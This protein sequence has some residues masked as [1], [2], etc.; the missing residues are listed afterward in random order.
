[1]LSTK[2]AVRD[3]Y[4]LLDDHQRGRAHLAGIPNSYI[5]EEAARKVNGIDDLKHLI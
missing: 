1:M 3:K 2:S 5:T 4:S